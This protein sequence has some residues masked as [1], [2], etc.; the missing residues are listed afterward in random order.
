MTTPS[1]TAS[2]FPCSQFA[3]CINHF[4]CCSSSL[5]FAVSG[6]CLSLGTKNRKA[7]PTIALH[8]SN[9]QRFSTQQSRYIFLHSTQYTANTNFAFCPK[10]K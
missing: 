5:C 7:V 1:N 3:K 9:K 6:F 8:K 4:I 10:Q 2:V